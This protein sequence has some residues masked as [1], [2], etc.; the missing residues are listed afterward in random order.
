M[1][2]AGISVA[3]HVR[4]GSRVL[5]NEE[6]V[7]K[8]GDPLQEADEAQMWLELVREVQDYWIKHSPVERR[9]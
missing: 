6:F 5:S 8:L 4:E 1:L 2:R 7:S 3:A 9:S